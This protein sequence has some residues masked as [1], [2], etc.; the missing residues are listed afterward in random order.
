MR[1]GKR[2]HIWVGVLLALLFLAALS[3]GANA[4]ETQSKSS[5]ALEKALR[6]AALQIASATLFDGSGGVDIPAKL[7]Q[8]LAVLPLRVGRGPFLPRPETEIRAHFADLVAQARYGN[9]FLFALVSPKDMAKVAGSAAKG[10]EMGEK[11]N[12]KVLQSAR[13]SGAD[14]VLWGVLTPPASG[15]REARWQANWFLMPVGGGN[16]NEPLPLIKASVYTTLVFDNN[17]NNDNE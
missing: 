8:R 10:L 6:Q 17:N 2:C 4:Q 3:G 15:A 12:E 5:D 1:L 16:K 7:P 13:K 9:A 14:Y 11:P